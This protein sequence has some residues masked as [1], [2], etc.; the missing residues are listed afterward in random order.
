MK[1]M[2]DVRKVGLKR[3]VIGSLGAVL[4]GVLVYFVHL[5]GFAPSSFAMIPLAIPGAYALMGI[6]EMVSGTDFFEIAQKW[7]DLDGWQRGVLG[8]L[9]VILAFAAL[10]AGLV[11][12]GQ[13]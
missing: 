9:V 7:D 2:S 13:P 3:F 4:V 6:V 1:M 10:F 11:L 8:T 12:F 5:Q